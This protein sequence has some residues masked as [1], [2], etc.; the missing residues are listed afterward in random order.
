MPEN[1]TGYS[2]GSDIEALMIDR[3]F[4]AKQPEAVKKL[5]KHQLIYSVAGLLL[6]FVCIIGGIVLFLNGLVGS[7]SWTAKFFGAESNLNDGAPGAVLFIVGLF[8]V[9]ITRYTL[10]VKN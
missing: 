2:E 4:A 7:T 6:G 3:D 5:S 8:I 10:K 1:K 9:L